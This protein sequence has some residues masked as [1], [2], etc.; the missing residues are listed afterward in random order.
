MKLFLLINKV[1]TLLIRFK[2]HFSNSYGKLLVNAKNNF[3][4]GCKFKLMFY[5]NI[6]RQPKKEFKSTKEKVDYL[7][8]K[9]IECFLEIIPYVLCK[10]LVLKK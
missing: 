5:L 6:L 1:V 4:L 7:E 3:F 9:R 8:N 10:E 2:A